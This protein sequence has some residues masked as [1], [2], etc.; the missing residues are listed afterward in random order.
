MPNKASGW[1]VGTLTDHAIYTGTMVHEKSAGSIAFPVVLTI[2]FA[3]PAPHALC[4]KRSRMLVQGPTEISF[5]TT[6][7]QES[8]V[9][10]AGAI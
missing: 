2:R 9:F 10:V 1:L 7:E 3:R 8:H 6:P 4:K 5:I